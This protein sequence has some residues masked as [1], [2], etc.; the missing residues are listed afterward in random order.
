MQATRARRFWHDRPFNIIGGAG[1]F[2][3]GLLHE[4]GSNFGR[5]ISRPILLWLGSVLAFSLYYLARGDVHFALADQ[6]PAQPNWLGELPAFGQ[7]LV[8]RIYEFAG[9]L[10]T[11]TC[12]GGTENAWSQAIALSLNSS[13]MQNGNF[14]GAFSPRST[15]CLFENMPLDILVLSSAQAV[16]SLLLGLLLLHAIYVRIRY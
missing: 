10:P 2:W 6:A 4:A 15:G 5:S 9:G 14:M 3:L 7:Q 16:F 1:R 8:A 11:L 13:L 12:N